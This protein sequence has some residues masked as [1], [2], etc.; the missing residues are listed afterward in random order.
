M[1][2]AASSSAPS[3]IQLLLGLE[4]LVVLA[5]S[6][7][8]SA[9]YSIIALIDAFTRGPL[10]EQ[11]TA[12]NRSASERPWFDLVYQLADVVFTLAP[13]ALVLLLLT[14]TGTRAVQAL[15]MDARRPVRDAL[16]GVALMACIGLP[17]LAIYYLGRA[18]GATLE[19][20]PAALDQHWWT[21][22]VLILHAL[23]NA[24]VEEV[25]VAGYLVLRLEQ[26][27]WHPVA[28][29]A[30]SAVLRGAYHLYQGV[31]PGLA[32]MLMGVVFAEWFRRTR[33]TMPLIIAHTLL[34]VV[35]FVGYAM[36]RDVIS[37]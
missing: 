34:D 2:P 19:V 35:A 30:S 18:L 28:I 26:M 11:S 15:G 33:R 14:V 1:Q 10:S 27:G 8:R 21:V 17:G 24:L 16:W 13:V 5:L 37:T 7:G 12:L 20:I 4:I 23:K 25:I 3:R 29:T 6:L 32:N 36:L 9:F 31:G 22:P